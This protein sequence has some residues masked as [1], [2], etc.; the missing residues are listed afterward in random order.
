MSPAYIE[1]VDKEFT[2]VYDEYN[3]RLALVQQLGQEIVN[4]WAELGIP[5][6]QTDSTIVK[7]WRDAPE[8]LGL[9]RDDV[10]KLQSRREKLHEEK[11]SREK[12]M[13]QLRAE[14]ESLWD[15][16]GAD[17]QE[18][19]AFLA[20]TR[21]CGLRTINDLEDE[22][23]RLNELK[24]Q[25]LHI[26]VEDARNK[27]QSM[28]DELYFSEEEAVEFTPMFSDIYSD[29]LL[30]AHEN[31]IARLEVLR[32]QR[33]P[34]ISLV[35]KHRSIVKDREDL[36]AASQDASRLM[37]NK[38]KGERRDPGKLLREEKMRKRIARELPKVEQELRNLLESFED[39]YGRPFLVFGERYL[40]ELAESKAPPP[41]S[42]T[43]NGL[44]PR[45]KTPNNPPPKQAPKSAPSS[46]STVRGASAREAPRA[47][48]PGLGSVRS[49]PFAAVAAS[50]PTPSSTASNK[51]PSRIPA[52]V[53]LGQ[54]ADAGNS[55]ERQTA[56]LNAALNGNQT[57][58][59]KPGALMA[60]PPKMRD[61]QQAMMPPTPVT[62]MSSDDLSRS[63]SVVRHV[64]PE[65]PYSDPEAMNRTYRQPPYNNA[66]PPSQE[67]RPASRDVMPPPPRPVHGY[68]PSSTSSVTSSYQHNG[69]STASS[70][71]VTSNDSTA[72]SGSENW[73]TYG[74]DEENE[75]AFAPPPPHHT[76]HQN[77]E[78]MYYARLKSASAKR[79]HAG[80]GHAGGKKLKCL[81][82][83]GEALVEG[84]SVGASQDGWE[85]EE[86]GETY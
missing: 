82:G 2:R 73:E 29:A 32:E 46:A 5:Q 39:E 68:A 64:A 59:G 40:D 76:G 48:T 52:R 18:R 6:A 23:T 45:A 19:K 4:L 30:S 43:P 27:L 25:N 71:R 36:S 50:R 35:A 58:R 1:S 10:E 17:E 77:S 21:G 26:F 44:P 7:N 22:L 80:D 16:L 31:E 14:V 9:H 79:A 65:D 83:V 63:G 51:S 37:A 34:I 33:G 85:D 13:S 55:P 53:P 15:R 66:R 8:Q 84:A 20:Q 75:E 70:I 61:L 74:S 12:R 38:G 69:P 3:R 54:R 67:Y 41:R 24:R 60:P 57:L 78:E 28:W 72:V 47:K 81:R 56:R 86:L 62:D 49:H 11:R 42:K